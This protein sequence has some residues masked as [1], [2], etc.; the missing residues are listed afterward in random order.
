M[1]RKLKNMENEK[2]PLDDLKM[3]KSLKNV[4]NEKCIYKGKHDTL[5]A[6]LRGLEEDFQIHGEYAGLH[7]LLTSK[8]GLPERW[9][10]EEAGKAGVRVYGLSAY[11]IHQHHNNRP[12][13]V[14]LGYAKLSEEQ[15][16]EGARRL[17][18]AWHRTT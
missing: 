8:K 10:V 18:E 15:I 6:R 11:Y 16:E 13:T 12:S 2:H 3:T 9:L 14:I 5:L 1:V 7:V 17:K 4:K